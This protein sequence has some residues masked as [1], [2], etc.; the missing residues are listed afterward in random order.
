MSSDEDDEY[1]AENA[2]DDVS[3]PRGMQDD[4]R[5]LSAPAPFFSSFLV[6]IE[7]DASE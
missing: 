7:K 2:D 1:L 5:S 4:V 6:L 3:L